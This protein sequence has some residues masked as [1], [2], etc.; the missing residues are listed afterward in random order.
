[1]ALTACTFS[2]GAN[3]ISV[4][5]A[6]KARREG[7]SR[8][9][10]ATLSTVQ[11]ATDLASRLSMGF[12][13]DLGFLPKSVMVSISMGVLAIACQFAHYFTDHSS[14]MVLA[15]LQGLFGG[16]R[17]NL[18]SVILIDYLGVERLAKAL[19]VSMVVMTLTIALSHLI[20]GGLEEATG[21]FDAPFY[22]I[23]A[24]LTVSSL[25]FLTE[26]L[27]R[28]LDQR[29]QMERVAAV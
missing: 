8:P 19:S 27:F 28:R 2:V 5:M 13:A 16:A 9:Q 25:V 15:C 26:P 4:Y 11:G 22:Y 14:M 6:S 17:H 10:T 24:M 29:K 23:S 7:L 18:Q 1:M 3:L 12:I 20:I 21:E